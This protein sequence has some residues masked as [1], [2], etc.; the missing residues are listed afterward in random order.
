MPNLISRSARSAL[1][2]LV[3][4]AAAVPATAQEMIYTA[5]TK[6]SF[7]DVRFELTNA[8]VNRGLVIDFSGRIADML[9]RTG[10]DVGSEKPLYKAAEYVSFC[11]A[12][13]S[14]QM[15]EADAANIAFCPYVVFFYETVARPGEV[16]VGYRLLPP[17]GDAASKSALAEVDKLLAAIVADA[18]K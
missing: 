3:V 5:K 18:V 13:L 4:L 8:I 16:V 6:S 14:R 9:A 7:D 2:L 17:S 12:K 15:M 1:P 10:R 11:S